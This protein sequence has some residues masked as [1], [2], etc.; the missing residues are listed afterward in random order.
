[1]KKLFDEIPCLENDRV[2]LRPVAEGDAEALREMTLNPV[3]YR[4]LPTFLYE[5]QDPDI[6]AVIRG[7]Y[8]DLLRAGGILRIQE[9]TAQ[10]QHRLPPVGAVLG[11]GD[12]STDSEAD[13]RLSVHRD[14]YGACHREHHGGECCVGKGSGKERF[15]QN[16]PGSGGLGL[17][18]ADSR[19]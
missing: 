5:Q 10:D 3:V 1:M 13:D 12:R 2:I 16:C 11:H 14:G 19:G 8:G 4:Y 6:H 15:S 18:E 9:H 7:F 17:S